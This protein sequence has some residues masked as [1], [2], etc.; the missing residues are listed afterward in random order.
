MLPAFALTLAMLNPTLTLE[1][2]LGRAIA[3]GV[4][5]YNDGQAAACAAV[6]ATALEAIGSTE[7]W[8]SEPAQRKS[9]TFQ[10]D[11]ATAMSDP[12]D[13]AWAYR[14]LIDTLLAGEPLPPIPE[15]S[16]RLLF[17]FS[18]TADVDRWQ[19]VLD[20]VMGG[21]STGEVSEENGSLVF[22]GDTSLANNGGFSSIRASVPAGSIAGY[23]ALRIRVRGD[24]RTWILGASGGTGNRGD[25]YWRRFDTDG[26]IWQTVTVP[27]REMTRVFFGRPLNGKLQPA[28][29]RGVEFYIYDKKAG[30]FRLEVDR[31]EAV[32][33]PAT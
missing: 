2:Y 28:A 32:R 12:R 10:L 1:D 25:S 21:R 26:A 16:E 3:R 17:D 29:L 30:P 18:Q 23:D 14:D 22:T 33:L 15:A 8:L 5:L 20:G 11:L 27:I 9:L 7:G 24:G 31:I 4:P 6:Y 13:R 19:V